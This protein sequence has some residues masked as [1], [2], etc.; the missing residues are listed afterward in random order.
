MSQLQ[1]GLQLTGPL[2][3][4]EGAHALEAEKSKRQTGAGA[5]GEGTLGELL[6][7]IPQRIPSGEA[8]PAR[9][10]TRFASPTSLCFFGAHITQAFIVRK[11]IFCARAS[12]EL[13]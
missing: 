5:S 10:H 12:S 8:D 11:D 1:V 4:A 7:D 9:S 3:V 6:S 2:L 13:Q